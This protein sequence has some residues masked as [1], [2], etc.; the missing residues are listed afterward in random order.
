MTPRCASHLAAPLPRIFSAWAC[1]LVL[2]LVA[3]PNAAAQHE[4]ETEAWIEMRKMVR[5][6]GPAPSI[7]ADVAALAGREAKRAGPRLI[8]RGP[9]VLPQVHAALLAPNVEARHA[10][11]LLQVMRPLSD[12]R[13]V[14]V[15]LELLERDPE[16]PLRR[17]ALL[18][19]AMLPVTDEAAAFI[20]A[21]AADDSEAWRTRRMA[22]TW[23][24]LQRD[25][26]GRPFAEALRDDPDPERRAAGLYV[27][28]RLGDESA[29]EPIGEMLAA[30]APNNARDVL[31]LAL[32]E[33]ATPEEFERMAPAGLGWSGGYKDAQRYVRYRAA[34]AD[35][36]PALCLEM[37]RAQMPGHREI[38]VRCLLDAGRAHDLRP[39]AALDMEAPGRDALL[40]NEI[41]KA[42]WQIIDT[43]TEFRIEPAQPAS[44]HK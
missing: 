1:L 34:A 29:L 9:E 31:L 38:A 3:A 26:R 28:A 23:Y 13:S 39:H 16:S 5:E 41:R 12:E 10:L 30:G 11:R 22:F 20:R 24:G 8:D 40:R 43:D 15:V 14:A 32:A 33:L 25:P 4:F 19:L 37:L 44:Q 36:R 18:V 42:G 17:D 27:L 35:A 6:K 7:E 2:A 21:I